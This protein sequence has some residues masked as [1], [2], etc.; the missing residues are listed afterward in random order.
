V[1]ANNKIVY[2]K[3]SLCFAALSIPAQVVERKEFVDMILSKLLYISCYQPVISSLPNLV[4]QMGCYKVSGR[5]RPK[6]I[7]W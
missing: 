6:R 2:D 1:P 4:G 5:G 3:F 7:F